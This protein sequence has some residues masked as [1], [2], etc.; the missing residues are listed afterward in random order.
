MC[1]TS[2]V[3]VKPDVFQ[4]ETDEIH[5]LLSRFKSILPAIVIDEMVCTETVLDSCWGGYTIL[6]NL[7]IVCISKRHR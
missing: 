4:T 7:N 1:E 2:V 6:I 3:F 5:C